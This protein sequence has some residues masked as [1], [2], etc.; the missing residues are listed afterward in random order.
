MCI[1]FKPATL[2]GGNVA[3]SLLHYVAIFIFHMSNT[4]V[5]SPMLQTQCKT[6]AEFS[7]S[8]SKSPQ[9]FADDRHK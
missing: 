2:K 5:S 1:S 9:K 6:K 7:L 4:A 3:V 8:S